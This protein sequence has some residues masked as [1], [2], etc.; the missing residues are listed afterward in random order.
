M[1]TKDKAQLAYEKL[2]D[3]WKLDLTGEQEIQLAKE[4]F[5]PLWDKFTSDNFEMLDTADAVPFMRELM[6]MSEEDKAKAEKKKSLS[7]NLENLSQSEVK[8][9]EEVLKDDDDDDKDYKA[10]LEVRE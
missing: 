1:I 5:D 8:D 2:F 6:S 7:K 9:S 10:D 3:K 4:H